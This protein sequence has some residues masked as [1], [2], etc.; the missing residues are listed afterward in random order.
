[1]NISTHYN[2]AERI[3]ET[4]RIHSTVL[5]Y[6]VA[7]LY[8]LKPPRSTTQRVLNSPV[9]PYFSLSHRLKSNQSAYIGTELAFIR[10]SNSPKMQLIVS[11]PCMA[12]QCNIT[13]FISQGASR[14]S[15]VRLAGLAQAGVQKMEFVVVQ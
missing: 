6:W 5:G 13:L 1:M 15:G 2:V 14:F 11:T 8:L 7:C 4:G 10:T 12:K 3:S 9:F